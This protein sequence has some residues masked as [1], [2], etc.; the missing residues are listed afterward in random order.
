MHYVDRSYLRRSNFHQL[1]DVISILRPAHSRYR[2]LVT[3]V[4]HDDSCESPQCS[5][6]AE[7]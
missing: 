6:I 7:T 1:P 5:T 4:T 2:R 3:E